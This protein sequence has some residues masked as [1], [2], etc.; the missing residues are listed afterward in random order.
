MPKIKDNNRWL[1]WF[2]KTNGLNRVDVAE[3]VCVN[4]STV[5]RWL[6]PPP[7]QGKP[8]TN[9]FRRM[10]DMARK[11]LTYMDWNGDFE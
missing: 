5:D 9:S 3:A 11:L 7:K 1:Q 8:P 10:P 2:M 6:L 4:K